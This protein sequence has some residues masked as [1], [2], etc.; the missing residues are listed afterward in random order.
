MSSVS[1]GFR[2]KGVEADATL[3]PGERVLRAL[4]LGDDDAESFRRARGIPRAAAEA[5]LASR[6][7]A[8]RLP[9]RVAGSG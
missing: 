4:K 3:T 6:R 1:D 8:G 7:R 2:R 5:E 9:S